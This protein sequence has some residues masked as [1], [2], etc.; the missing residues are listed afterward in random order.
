MNMSNRANGRT[1]MGAVMGSKGLKAIVFDHAGGQKPPIVNPDAF[2]IAS[3]DYTKS[4]M[5]HPDY[6]KLRERLIEFLEVHAHKKKHKPAAADAGP[7]PSAAAPKNNLQL[8]T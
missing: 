5:E 1:G 4:V 6:Y 8:V 3:K 7:R 2:K